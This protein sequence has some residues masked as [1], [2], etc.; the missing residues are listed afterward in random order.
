MDKTSLKILLATTLLVAGSGMAMAKGG[1]RA[2]LSFEELDVDGSG[3]ITTEDF[4]QLREARF[5]EMDANGDGSVTIEEFTA[6]QAAR[7][8][9]RATDTFERL[10]A[11]GDGLLSRDVLENRGRGDRMG[12]RML[13]RFDT[14]NSG[15][16]SAEEFD[17]ARARISER[18]KG[19]QRGNGRNRN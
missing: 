10:D 13:T 7:A 9:E 5:A 1:D 17:E 4:Q 19:A 3:E 14:D 18:R 12:T 11:D 6:A 8:S 16:L 15:G 2:A